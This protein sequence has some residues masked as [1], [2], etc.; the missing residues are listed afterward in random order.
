MFQSLLDI[1]PEPRDTALH[2]VLC[3]VFSPIMTADILL[4]QRVMELLQVGL[5]EGSNIWYVFLISFG[6]RL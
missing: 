3:K 5:C 2:H 4:R 1:Q 6:E